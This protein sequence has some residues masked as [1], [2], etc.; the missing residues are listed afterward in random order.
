[1]KEKRKKYGG[2]SKVQKVA[3]GK[4]V[5]EHNHRKHVVSARPHYSKENAPSRT[6]CQTVD[7]LRLD[8][9]AVGWRAHIFFIKS[10]QVKGI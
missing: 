10:P 1:M 7:V 2:N 3:E 9:F 4:H 6:S 5:A 8:K